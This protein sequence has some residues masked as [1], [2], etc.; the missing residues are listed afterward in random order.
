MLFYICK[1][2]F[3]C[4]KFIWEQFWSI[5]LY[6]MVF[7]SFCKYFDYYFLFYPYNCILLV[8]PAKI[9]SF[10]NVLGFP[11]LTKNLD[12]VKFR[13]VDN[14][15]YF[16]RSIFKHYKNLFNL[17]LCKFY[18][19]ILVTYKCLHSIYIQFLGSC[20]FCDN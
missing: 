3:N 13:N 11:T 17:F 2:L 20:S 18:C 6:F 14:V 1:F 15:K 9:C 12:N 16:L 4:F 10:L 5:F 19:E 8:W 7:V